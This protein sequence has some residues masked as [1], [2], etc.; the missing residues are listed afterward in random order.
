MPGLTE[1]WITMCCS[2]LIY[3]IL[4][5]KE[6]VYVLLILSVLR[7]L[8]VVQAGEIGTVPPKYRAWLRSGAHHFD[9]DLA[10]TDSAPENEDGCRMYIVS[11]WALAVIGE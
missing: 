5:G 8:P 3:E 7:R 4:Q 6:V 2:S 9:H 11:S 1:F 10:R